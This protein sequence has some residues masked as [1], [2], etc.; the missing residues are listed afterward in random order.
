MDSVNHTLVITISLSYLSS[1]FCL[2]LLK[3]AGFHIL[4]CFVTL[5]KSWTGSPCSAL[6]N[7]VKSDSSKCIILAWAS[8]SL[9]SCEIELIGIP[10]SQAC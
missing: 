9:V 7:S 8:L 3:L 6:G 1:G 10:I 2:L 4:I 5:I